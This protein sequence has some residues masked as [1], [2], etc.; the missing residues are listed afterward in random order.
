MGSW[1]NG[2]WVWNLLWRRNLWEFELDLLH[3]LLVSL[4]L[5]VPSL[6]Q[7]DT[8][9]WLANSDGRY[10]VKSAYHCLQQPG[11]A[12][13]EEV[14]KSLWGV[15]VPSNALAFTW[16]VLQN[17]I[18]TR[19]NL[20]KRHIISSQVDLLCPLCTSHEESS[21]HLLFSCTVAWRVWMAIYNWIGLSTVLPNTGKDHFLQHVLLWWTKSQKQGAWVL[22]IAVIWAIWNLRNNL[23]FRNGQLDI[24]KMLDGIQFKTWS[25]LRGKL[26][27]FQYNL[28][29]WQAQPLLCINSL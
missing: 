1:Q 7:T 28:Y 12:T 29:E 19:D 9:V 11:M 2:V 17:R 27:G 20:H 24:A 26:K 25:W 22:W 15:P 6:N 23:I 5:F 16:K 10:T 14:F 3:H 4:Q 18:Q 21:S 8:W 13:G